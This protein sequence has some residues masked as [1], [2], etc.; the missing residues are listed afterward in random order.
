MTAPKL[1][2]LEV[3]FMP[4]ARECNLSM[5]HGAMGGRDHVASLDE[6]E[7]R[8]LIAQLTAWLDAPRLAAP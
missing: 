6:D 4:G 2:R 3:G 8:D 7:A 1:P 5:Y